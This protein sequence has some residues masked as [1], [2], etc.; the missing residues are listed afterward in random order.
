MKKY[1]LLILLPCVCN[2][3]YC[4]QAFNSMGGTGKA[5]NISMDWSVGEITLVKTEKTGGLTLTQGLL[6]GKLEVYVV[7]SNIVDAELTILPN[8]TAGMLY[9]QTGFLQQGKL[10]I[11]LYNA[12]G[13]IMIQKEEILTGFSTKNINLTAF[14]GGTYLMQ[15]LFVPT[16]GAIKKRTYKIVKL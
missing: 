6:Q 11:Q 9:L 13:Q 7:S 16:N 2:A 8:P 5:I 10:Q 1:L 14:A 15:V 4:Q 12:T 3:A